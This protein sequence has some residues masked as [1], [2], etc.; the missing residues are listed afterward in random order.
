MRGLLDVSAGHVHVM[1]GLLD[2]S[3]GL[4]DVRPVTST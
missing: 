1:R 4:L 2:V 3:A